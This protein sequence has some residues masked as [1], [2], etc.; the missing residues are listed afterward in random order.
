M[1]NVQICTVV[2][3][4]DETGNYSEQRYDNVSCENMPKDIVADLV[5]GEVVCV[6]ITPN[7]EV[8]YFRQPDNWPANWAQLGQPN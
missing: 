3:S 1:N 6:K 4:Y 2:R 8:F 7:V 5:A